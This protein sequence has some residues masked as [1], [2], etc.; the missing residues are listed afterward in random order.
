VDFWTKWWEGLL[1]EV[2]VYRT[3]LVV[4]RMVSSTEN[5]ADITY[6]RGHWVVEWEPAHLTHLG[7]R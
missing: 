7:F 4:G 2:L 5:T 6:L 3:A 1:L